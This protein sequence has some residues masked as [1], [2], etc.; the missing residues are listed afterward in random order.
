[1]ATISMGAP[2]DGSNEINATTS[3]TQGIVGNSL[4]LA[5]AVARKFEPCAD[6][7]MLWN[8]MAN[9]KMTVD[10]SVNIAL[11]HLSCFSDLIRTQQKQTRPQTKRR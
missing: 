4:P 7:S 1:M 9:M 3:S 10:P 5:S 8:Q 11:I 6:C 2:V